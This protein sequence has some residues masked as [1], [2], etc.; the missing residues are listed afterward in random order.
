MKD[1]TR[2]CQWV[3]S[4]M[5]FY[6]Q[7]DF[8]IN[9]QYFYFVNMRSSTIITQ[10]DHLN[11]FSQKRK[12]IWLFVVNHIR[13][14]KNS[15][16]EY[17]QMSEIYS[18][19]FSKRSHK[20]ITGWYHLLELTSASLLIRKLLSC[21]S[22]WEMKQDIV[23][24]SFHRWLSVVHTI[25]WSID[26]IFDRK[27]YYLVNIR[28]STITQYDHLNWFSQKR[29]WIYDFCCQPHLLLKLVIQMIMFS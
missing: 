24:G 22:C 12:W 2:Y 3:F 16:N 6:C 25:S 8:L 19:F 1:E 28:S 20:N 27:I 18:R 21:L 13:Y 26:S 29:K 23:D 11:W 9:Q 17:K 7:Q 15:L 5:T 14:Q 10:C 4:S